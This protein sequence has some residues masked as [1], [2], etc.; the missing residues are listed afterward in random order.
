MAGRE[1]RP[2]GA[3]DPDFG[4]ERDRLAAGV[5]TGVE[6]QV[7]NVGASGRCEAFDDGGEFRRRLGRDG[8]V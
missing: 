4:T 8:H 2:D 5:T 1:A 3:V 6:R 7:G